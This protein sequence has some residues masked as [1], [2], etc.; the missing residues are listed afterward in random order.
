MTADE[1]V[2]EGKR[3]A[4]M[5]HLVVFLHPSEEWLAVKEQVPFLRYEKI[6]VDE[7]TAHT[8]HIER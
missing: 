3:R 6:P 8:I 5:G 7:P 4:A 1:L 2:A